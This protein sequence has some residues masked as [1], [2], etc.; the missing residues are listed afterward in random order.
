MGRR[1]DDGRGKE[2]KR[3]R[4]TDRARDTNERESSARGMGERITRHVEHRLLVVIYQ[5]ARVGL[6]DSFRALMSLEGGW[7]ASPFR[8]EHLIMVLHIRGVGFGGG[9]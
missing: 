8:A 7:D 1:Y 3:A 9:L 2:V 4:V 6:A 5:Q